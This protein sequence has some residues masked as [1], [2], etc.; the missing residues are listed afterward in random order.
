[1]EEQDYA[2]RRRQLEKQGR[3]KVRPGLF[4]LPARYAL[5]YATPN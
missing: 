3:E 2:G 4:K 5:V 1:M